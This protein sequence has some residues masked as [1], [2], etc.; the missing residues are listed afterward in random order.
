MFLL[1]IFYTVVLTIVCLI[2]LNKMPNIGMSNGDKIFHLLAYVVLTFLW[3]KT[4]LFKFGF[5]KASSLLYIGL[6]CIIFGIIIEVLQNKL[7]TYRTLDIL[8][9]L[10]NTTGVILAVLVLVAVVVVVFEATE[11]FLI[12]STSSSSSPSKSSI[13]L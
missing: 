8:D 4:F 13:N 10:A 1:S 6:F 3:V 7:T 9:I 2:K 5:K 11:F 12:K